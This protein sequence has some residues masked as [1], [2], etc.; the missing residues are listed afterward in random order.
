MR[1]SSPPPWLAAHIFV[2]Q[3]STVLHFR[4]GLIEE[5][6]LQ[7]KGD[8][9]EHINQKHGV[10]SPI[11]PVRTNIQLHKGSRAFS[12]SLVTR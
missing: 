7:I 9:M 5:I 12:F 8:V 2:N 6:M 3:D 10:K 4:Y 11:G 1:S